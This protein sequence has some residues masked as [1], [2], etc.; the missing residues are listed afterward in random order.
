MILPVPASTALAHR[1]RLKIA[2]LVPS[3]V[4]ALTRAFQEWYDA[5]RLEGAQ[6]RTRGRHWL[7]YL[8]LRYTGARLGEVLRLD[9]RIDLDT[10][11]ADFHLP[12]LKRRSVPPKRVVPVPPC[13]MAEIATYL[14]DW[15]V[16]RGQVFRLDPSNFRKEFAARAREAGVLRRTRTEDGRT[17]LFPH[18]HSMRHTRAIELLAAG[19]PVTAVQD[20]L[21]HSSLL[22]TAEYLRLSGQDIKNILRD[23]GLA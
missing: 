11:V 1:G 6:R 4:E 9:D 19:V 17:C 10:R 22:T 8:V 23:K 21:G 3:E 7:V 5:A 18:P 12:T 15:P 20:L 16:M 14:L 13:L 2:Y